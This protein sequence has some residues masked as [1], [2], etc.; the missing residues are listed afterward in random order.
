M[1]VRLVTRVRRIRQAT[2]YDLR[3]EVTAVPCDAEGNPRIREFAVSLYKTEG[4]NPPELYEVTKIRYRR[5]LEEKWT[6]WVDA[7]DVSGITVPTGKATGDKYDSYVIEAYYGD[8]LLTSHTV[9][10]VLDGRIGNKGAQQRVRIWNK[11]DSY[12]QGKDDEQWYD[13]ALYRDNEKLPYEKYLCLVSHAPRNISPKDDVAQNL[14]FW[15]MASEFEFIATRLL[16]A[17]RI[18]ADQIDADG[19]TAKDVNVTGE[20]HIT[21]GDIGGFEIANQRIGVKDGENGFGIY[22]NVSKYSNSTTFVGWGYSCKPAIIGYPVLCSLE[23]KTD[24]NYDRVIA[25]N[26][27]VKNSKGTYKGQELIAINSAGSHIFLQR[28]NDKWNAPGVLWAAEVGGGYPIS[29]KNAWGDGAP[30]SKIERLAKGT[31]RITHNLGSADWMPFIQCFHV[32]KWASATIISRDENS[33]TF[34]THENGGDG[35]ID[36]DFFVTIVGR[37]KVNV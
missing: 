25:L 28:D 29:L 34:T 35:M 17:E 23:Y 12:L 27:D 9:M 10:T 8:K 36:S 31:Y 2:R 19:M 14:G 30:V 11:D 7:S 13:I 24:N 18:K 5:C 20:A 32:D 16:L 37:N 4:N 6:A 22:P 33:F 15:A 1:D 21:E 26:I 3:S